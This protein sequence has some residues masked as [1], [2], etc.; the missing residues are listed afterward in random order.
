VS[1]KFR[2]S[3]SA[4]IVTGTIA[5]FY[6]CTGSGGN[7][8]VSRG[9]YLIEIGGCNDCHTSGYAL[10]GGAT[11]EAQWLLGD[12]LG[13]RGGWGTTYAINLRKYI[14]KISEIDWI[15][16][17][18]TLKARPPMPWWALNTMTEQDLSEI[19]KY[20]KSLEII[21]DSVPTYLP[22]G[23][24]PQTPYIQWPIPPE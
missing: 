7:I 14:D 2:S 9:K 8:D 12:S 24:E 10:S 17:A 13:F 11:P 16:K 19:Y 22:P 20:I 15:T 6:V 4:A 23:I 21:D 3:I 1:L 18:K 5:L